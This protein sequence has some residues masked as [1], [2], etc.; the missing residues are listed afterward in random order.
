MFQLNRHNPNSHSPLQYPPSRHWHDPCTSSLSNMRAK[1][2][3]HSIRN[4]LTPILFCAELALAGDR[5]AQEL[6]VKEL[7]RHAD[8]IQAEL[9]ILTRAVRSR[10][11]AEETDLKDCTVS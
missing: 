10:T 4:E 7:V 6:V 2:A 1:Q 5:E 8:S 11:P 9:D 3:I